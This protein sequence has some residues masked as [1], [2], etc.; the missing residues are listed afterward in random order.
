MNE[1]KCNWEYICDQ[2]NKNTTGKAVIIEPKSP[3]GYHQIKFYDIPFS[4]E[5]NN[6]LYISRNEWE[7]AWKVSGYG[8]RDSPDRVLAFI[9]DIISQNAKVSRKQIQKKLLIETREIIRSSNIEDNIKRIK[10]LVKMEDEYERSFAKYHHL[11]LVSK[12][13]LSNF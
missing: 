1:R 10:N 11:K 6:V 8:M 7:R 3:N 2:L 12:G 5:F 4:T 13:R 9:Y